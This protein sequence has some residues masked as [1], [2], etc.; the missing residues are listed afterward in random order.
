ML[1]ELKTAAP[2]SP[3]VLPETRLRRSVNVVPLV[4]QGDAAGPAAVAGETAV[5]GHDSGSAGEDRAAAA[6]ARRAAAE[7]VGVG[8]REVSQRERAPVEPEEAGVVEAVERDSA[9][10]RARVDGEVAGGEADLP[11]REWERGAVERR[12]ECDGVSISG[13]GDG[14]T[15]RAVGVAGAVIGVGRFGDNRE[16]DKGQGD[17]PIGGC[18]CSTSP[19]R[20]RENG[21]T[22]G[23]ERRAPETAFPVRRA[24]STLVSTASSAIRSPIGDR[25]L[26]CSSASESEPAR[27]VRI[28]SGGRRP[29]AGQRAGTPPLGSIG[30]CCPC[31]AEP[32]AAARQPAAPTAGGAIGGEAATPIPTVSGTA[33]AARGE[34]QL[35][36]PVPYPQHSRPAT[37]ACS[38]IRRGA[39]CFSD[40]HE[41]RV[42][43]EH[44]YISF[45]CRAGSS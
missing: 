28:D 4:I 39:P 7:A 30:T 20:T 6:V 21:H 11:E 29:A 12:I 18:P 37:A 22:A 33:A 42:S 32:A 10:E 1:E 13:C 44:V 5:L 16:R 8:E 9:C 38:L 35:R 27:C 24:V 31:N 40:D 36:D 41:Q 23:G 34:E 43:R 2:W 15:E 26:T 19:V 14:F 3:A 45:E 17:L 25:D